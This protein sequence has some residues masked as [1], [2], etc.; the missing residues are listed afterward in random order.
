MAAALFV[1]RPSLHYLN[2]NVCLK[3]GLLSVRNSMANQS[4]SFANDSRSAFRRSA[5]SPT[6]KERLMAPQQGTGK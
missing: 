6:L 2:K 4:K 5:R 3:S 1:V